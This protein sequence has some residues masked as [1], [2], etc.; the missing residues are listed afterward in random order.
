MAAPI[1]T[2]PENKPMSGAVWLLALIPL[3]LLGIV[4]TSLLVTNGGL[5]E[6]AGPPVEQIAIERIVLPEPGVIEVNVVNDGPQTVIDMLKAN[7]DLDINHYLEVNFQA[8]AQ[9]VD[10]IGT[11]G[12]YFPQPT[13]DFDTAQQGDTGFLV[14]MQVT[15]RSGTTTSRSA[16]VSL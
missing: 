12:V 14:P 13:R 4:L 3:I 6:L 2:S 9:L 11:I 16:A 7:F 8:F 15:G 10:A 5:T 1:Q